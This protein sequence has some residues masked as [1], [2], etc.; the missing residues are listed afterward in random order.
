MAFGVGVGVGVD[1]GS[2]VGVETEIGSDAGVGSDAGTTGNSELFVC[3]GM[4][5]AGKTRSGVEVVVSVGAGAG[6][7]GSV[8][9]GGASGASTKADV[10]TPGAWFGSSDNGTSPLPGPTQPEN[11]SMQAR[12]AANAQFAFFILFPPLCDFYNLEDL[13]TQ[14]QDLVSTWFTI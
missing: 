12:N 3:S 13:L 10:S 2:G 11:N 1:S 9:E 14:M 6:F 8:W 7:E 5:V 4:G